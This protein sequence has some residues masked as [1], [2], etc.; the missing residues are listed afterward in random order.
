ML[1]HISS[2]ALGYNHPDFLARISSLKDKITLSETPDNAFPPVELSQ[3]LKK[4]LIK[5]APR[6]LNE[7]VVVSDSGTEANESAISDALA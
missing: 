7:V 1:S 4:S 2:S 6:G 5:R 3:M